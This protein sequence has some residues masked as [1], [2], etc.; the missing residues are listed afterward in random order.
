MMLPISNFLSTITSWMHRVMAIGIMIAAVLPL[1]MAVH[2][3]VLLL[4]VILFFEIKNKNLSVVR[5]RC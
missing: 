2:F 5:H 4:M 3:M 1:N